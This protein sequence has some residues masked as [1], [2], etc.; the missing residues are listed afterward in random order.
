MQIA[1]PATH[2]T[3]RDIAL[4]RPGY[5]S[6]DVEYAFSKL[7]DQEMHFQRDVEL[8]KSH[9]TACYDFNAANL[10]YAADVRNTGFIN[11]EDLRFFMRE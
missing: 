9:L 6:Y 8:R 2:A 1:L 7:L 10:F 5:L 3:F 4:G 11:R